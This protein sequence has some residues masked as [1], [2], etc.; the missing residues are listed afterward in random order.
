MSMVWKSNWTSFEAKFQTLQSWWCNF[1]YKKCYK[2][3][4]YLVSYVDDILITKNNETYISSM[5]KELKKRFEMIA[6]GHLNYFFGIEVIQNPKY[7]FISQKKYV[8]KLLN[9]FGITDCSSL[10][11]LMEHNLNLTSKEGNEFEDATKY[12]WLVGSLIYLTTIRSDISYVVSILSKFMK[13]PCEG[14]W[15]TAKRVLRYLKGTQ[16]YGLKY[17]KMDEFNLIAHSNLDFDGG[18]ENGVSTSGYLTRIG[19][20]VVSWRSCKQSVPIDSTT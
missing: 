7:V 11:T 17:T 13:K 16:D 15:S 3:I 10:S 20:I 1:V 12:K 8:G 6:L 19:S 2:I 18:K 5:N 14:Y 9:I 4:V